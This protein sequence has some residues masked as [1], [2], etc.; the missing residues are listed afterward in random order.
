MDYGALDG[1]APNGM[2]ENGR[3]LWKVVGEVEPAPH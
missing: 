2:S 3:E 1:L